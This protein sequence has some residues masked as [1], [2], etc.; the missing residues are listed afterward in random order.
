[1]KLVTLSI[2]QGIATVTLNRP[3][4][5]NALNFEMFKQLD[6]TIKKLKKE[7]QVRVVLLTAQG[8][9]FCTGLD[10]KSVMKSGMSVVKLLWKWLPGNQ[11]LAQRV[12]LGWQSL[13]MPVIA[14]IN[15]R[16]WG[17]GTQIVLGADY[18]IA[19]PDASF[20]I[21][22]ARWGLAP[23]M[24]ASLSLSHLI[25]RDQALLLSSTAEPFSADQALKLGL[26]T[27]TDAEP[28][29]Y[30][31][32]LAQ[33]LMVRSPDT[34]AAIKRLYQT[35][36]GAATRKTLARE[37][38]NQVRLLLSKNTRIAINNQQADH[39][40]PYQQAKKW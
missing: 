27:A 39:T 21:M 24:G 40:T 6:A 11:N 35:S 34:L 22:E 2:E 15:G 1:M 32:Q 7:R 28:L 37:T 9:D 4:K 36:Y 23:D 16:C 29:T 3:D 12:V 26:L 18:R 20:A 8:A 10:V 31:R 5:L 13:P 38:Y 30:A 33:S 19:S 17:G 14:V 25:G